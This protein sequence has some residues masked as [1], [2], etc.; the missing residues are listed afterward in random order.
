M[1]YLNTDC[2]HVC[3]ACVDGFGML[4]CKNCARKE[5]KEMAMPTEKELNNAIKTCKWRQEFMGVVICSG[6]CGPCVRVI[7]NGECDTLK[8]IFAGK[9]NINAE[10]NT[11]NR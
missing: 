9:E 5:E 11:N 10:D 2:P 8:N 1:Q 6:M 4:K 3:R 7:E